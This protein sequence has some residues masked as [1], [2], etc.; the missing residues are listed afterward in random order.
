MFRVRDTSQIRRELAHASVHCAF[1]KSIVSISR[2]GLTG[3]MKSAAFIVLRRSF[4]LC[5]SRAIPELFARPLNKELMNTP[6]PCAAVLFLHRGAFI[7][8]LFAWQATFLADFCASSLAN[9]ASLLNSTNLHQLGYSEKLTPTIVSAHFKKFDPNLM[10][11]L[12]FKLY[13]L[14]S[15]ILVRFFFFI[16]ALKKICILILETLQ[17]FLNWLC[18]SF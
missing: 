11:K 14:F 18:K 3:F 16:T 6:E 15:T 17:K 5:A 10:Y 4:V 7:R 12:R 2:F 9:A 8:P 1:R 13:V